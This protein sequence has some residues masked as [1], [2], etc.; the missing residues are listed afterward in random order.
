MAIKRQLSFYPETDVDLYLTLATDPK[1][2]TKSINDAIRQ[3]MYLE[4]MVDLNDGNRPVLFSQLPEPV[5]QEVHS[6]LIMQD[7]SLHDVDDHIWAIVRE[8][9]TRNPIENTGRYLALHQAKF[10]KPFKIKRVRSKEE[11]ESR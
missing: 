8:T 6:N 3:G 10:G 11:L 7:L 9:A 1:K 4:A 2:K 5:K